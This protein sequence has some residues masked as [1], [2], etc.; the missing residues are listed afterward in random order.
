MHVVTPED[1]ER[2]QT[3][4]GIDARRLLETRNARVIHMTIEPGA[5]LNPHTTPV[6]VLFFVLAGAGMLS[7][8][9]EERVVRAGSL[10]GSP[11][12]ELHS[13]R[14]VSGEPL[15][16]LIVKTPAPGSAAPGR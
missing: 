6:D 16:L 11:A 7:A 5:E 10:V 4:P 1:A 8:G 3:P 12:G 2:L 9:G 14:N 15:Q 13:W